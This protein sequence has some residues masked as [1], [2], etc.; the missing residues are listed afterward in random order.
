MYRLGL[1]SIL[2]L[3][4][5]G[6]CFAMAP[7]IP[8][9]WERFRMV[10][11]HN[12]CRYRIEVRN[13]G[14]RSHGV[15]SATLDGVEVDPAAIPLASDGAEHRLLVVM[16]EPSSSAARWAAVGASTAAMESQDE[17]RA[18]PA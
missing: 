4:P 13:P 2:G 17:S 6:T 11:N 16:G 5:L 14:R 10:W 3:R 12:G 7:C 9:S 8:A 15:A 18:N 1:E